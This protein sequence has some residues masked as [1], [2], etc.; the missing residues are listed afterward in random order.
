MHSKCYWVLFPY[1][2]LGCCCI[3]ARTSSRRG[4]WEKRINYKRTWNMTQPGIE[5]GFFRL[6]RTLPTIESRCTPSATRSYP[7]SWA[8]VQVIENEAPVRTAGAEFFSI[9]TSMMIQNLRR[10]VVLYSLRI[11]SIRWQRRHSS[12]FF[13]L[14]KSM[15]ASSVTQPGVEPEE[16][17][18]ML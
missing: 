6:S 3:S 14:K 16:F 5:P 15:I 9:W 12:H 18:R 11:G 13:L 10:V 17:L 2:I 8:P 1:W 7:I 4:E